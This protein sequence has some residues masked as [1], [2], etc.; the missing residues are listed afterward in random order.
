[1]FTFG[2]AEGSQFVREKIKHAKDAIDRSHEMLTDFVR[3]YN[4]FLDKRDAIE[5]SDD[6]ISNFLQEA[7]RDSLL[8]DVL[9]DG[10]EN[11][12]AIRKIAMEIVP[13]L[14]TAFGAKTVDE[15]FSLLEPEQTVGGWEHEVGHVMMGMGATRH[16]DFAANYGIW[17]LHNYSPGGWMLTN[18][19]NRIQERQFR[20]RPGTPRASLFDSER[21]DPANLAEPLD[22]PLWLDIPPAL[23]GYPENPRAISGGDGISGSKS[24]TAYNDALRS[25]KRITASDYVDSMPKSSKAWLYPDGTL[26]PVQ[27]H[28]ELALPEDEESTLGSELDSF[29]QDAMDAGIIRID[30][31]YDFTRPKRP[32]VSLIVDT[33]VRKLTEPQIRAMRTIIV[34]GMVPAM[35]Y[36][37]GGLDPVRNFI[38]DEYKYLS[39]IDNLGRFLSNATASLSDPVNIATT[40]DN[41]HGPLRKWKK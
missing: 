21:H 5:V 19:F 4:Q 1:M 39:G 30:L 14:I 38:G 16:G 29:W 12:S 28:I 7:E 37:V 33:G 13:E 9:F 10:M 25:G 23:F 36:S 24:S 3:I 34:E 22:I 2:D 8:F 27:M 20:H 18:Y 32:P 11:G 6:D 31:G 15:A 40:S 41:Y 35:F 26:L 17:M